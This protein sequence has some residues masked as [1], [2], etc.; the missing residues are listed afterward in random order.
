M[1]HACEVHELSDRCIHPPIERVSRKVAASVGFKHQ[2]VTT[3]KKSSN[4]LHLA[5]YRT[6]TPSVCSMKGFAKQQYARAETRPLAENNRLQVSVP[7]VHS[8]QGPVRQS[9]VPDT[10][11]GTTAECRRRTRASPHPR[12]RA[13]PR[14]TLMGVYSKVSFDV[15]P[16]QLP[17]VPLNLFS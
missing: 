5:H 9:R 3:P 8:H 4:E 13:H 7:P 14:P 17:I 1:L 11:S 16:I 2:P 6:C 10:V 12:K 15:E